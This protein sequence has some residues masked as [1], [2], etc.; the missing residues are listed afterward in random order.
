MAEILREA[1]RC[2]GLTNPRCG[3][4]GDWVACVNVL[5]AGFRTFASLWRGLLE[6]L[7]W[8]H[9]YLLVAQAALLCVQ[10]FKRLLLFG[11]RCAISFRGFFLPLLVKTFFPGQT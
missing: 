2:S 11:V 7:N 5:M 10:G 6:V 9:W 4:M 3:S 1:A 8:R